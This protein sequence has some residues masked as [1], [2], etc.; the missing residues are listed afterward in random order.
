MPENPR[1]LALL[2]LGIL[3]VTTPVWAPPLDITGREYEYSAA[4]VTVEDNRVEVPRDPPIPGDIAVIDCFSGRLPSRLCGFESSLIGSNSTAAPY[5]GVR[6]VSGDPS[7]E[8]PG[9]YVAFSDGRIFERTTD[10][11]ESAQ[12]YA[13]GLERVDATRVLEEESHPIEQYQA[14][15]RRAVE[16]GSG[17]ADEPLEDSV[18]VESSGRYYAVYTTGSQTV[19]SEEPFTE[20]VFE[21]VAIASGA[22]LL[23]RCGTETS[24][25]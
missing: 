17:H 24:R 14:P 5:P 7:L 2:A 12:A 6:H 1:Q 18:L 22:L 4:L 19:L 10:W 21:A 23:C 16:T 3:L 25:G 9:R 15:V 8:A 13:L 20:R 11:N